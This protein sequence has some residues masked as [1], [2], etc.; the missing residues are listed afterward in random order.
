MASQVSPGVVLRERDLT[1]TTIVGNSALTAA[2]ASS[3]QKG[4]IGEITSVSSLKEFVGIFGTPS[5]AN[6]EDWLVA[7]EFLGYGGRLAVV[8]AESTVLNATSDGSAVL[9]KNEA[10]YTSGVGGAEVFAARTAGTWGNSLK[11]VAVDRGADQ[12]LTLASA[13]AT[14]TMNTAFTTVSGKAGRIYSWDAA[15]SQLAVILDNPTSLL[16]SAEVFD[17]PGDGVV[18]GVTPAA[19][20]GQGSQNGSHVV[21]PTG[22]TGTGLRLQ[23]I[24]DVGGSVTSVTIVN[25]G[26]GYAQGDS[27]TCPAADLGTGAVADLTVSVDSVSND[28]IAITSVKDWYTN[29]TI[30]GTTLKLSAIGPRPGTSQ[31]ASDRGISYDEIHLAVID[32]TGNVS[33]AADTVLERLTYLSKLTDAKNPEG[34]SL[35]FKDIVNLESEYIF[36]SGALTNLIEPTQGGG[37]EAL[38]QAST[39]LSSGS[40]LLLT[41]DNISNLSG[42]ADDYAYTAGEVNGAYDLFL[43]TEATT[44]DFILMGGSMGTENDT[45]AKAQK[46]VA[47]AAGRKDALAFVSPHKGNQIGTGGSALT[48]ADQRTNTVNFF[49]AISSTSFAVLDSGYKLSLIHI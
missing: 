28:N 19:Y 3:F 16:T 21:D 33:G 20:A 42:G 39:V 25:G 14:T 12:I 10:D 47:V 29:T 38:G 43:D 41:A 7:S 37:G 31:F 18:A 49:N 2:F 45:L 11:V 32:V 13:P 48:A 5:E 1:N 4:P 9:I 36:T 6:A 40:K 30:A 27:V 8:R 22:G 17:E 46:V 35:Y 34:A 24:I 26:T 23:V 44:I 15:T